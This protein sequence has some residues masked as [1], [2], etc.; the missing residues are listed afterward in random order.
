M[1]MKKINV[2]IVSAALSALITGHV[3]MSLQTKSYAEDGNLSFENTEV[4]QVS[5]DEP[6]TT[7]YF[8]DFSGDVSYEPVAESPVYEPVVE[9]PAPVVEAS[10]PAVEAPASEESIEFGDGT[11]PEEE[12]PVKR[13][14]TEEEFI[15]ENDPKPTPTP[16][17]STTPDDPTPE[18]PIPGK[19]ED[20]PEKDIEVAVVVSKVDDEGKAVIGATLQILDQNGKVLDEWI[21]DGTV[22]VAL[23]KEGTYVLHEKYAPKGYILAA[24]Q[25]FNVKVELEEVIAGVDHDDSP[26]V[27]S[28][29]LGVALYYIESAG[30]KEEVYC[31]NQDLR[32]PNGINYDGIILTAEK[33]REYAPKATASISDEELYDKILDIIYHRTIVSDLFPELSETAIRWITEYALKTYT[34]AEVETER[35]VRDEYGNLVRDAYGNI[36]YENIKYFKYYRYDENDPKGY[37]ID[38]G[39]G[40]GLGLLAEH[41][42]NQHGNTKLPIE[43]VN[44]FRYLVSNENKHPNDMYLYIYTAKNITDFGEIYQNLLGVKWY[45]PYAEGVKTYL[46]VVNEREVKTE[47]KKDINSEQTEQYVVAEETPK[48]GDDSFPLE[49][50]L[51]LLGSVMGIAGATTLFVKSKKKD[52]NKVKTLNK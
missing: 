46:T 18:D 15:E 44:L 36:V 33:I 17:P 21:S 51:L 35:A 24:D 41:W 42:Y 12:I 38:P 20:E 26:E 34:S 37:V 31:I 39:N 7:I 22:H 19:P 5:N 23:L 25:V 4:T 43:Y 2:R 45:D 52:K 47:S 49:D 14:I 32:E 8:G 1:N 27:C 50:G 29:N 28:H 13:I 48:T 3:G 30:L 16:V 11:E 9:A 40:D 10:E 6:V